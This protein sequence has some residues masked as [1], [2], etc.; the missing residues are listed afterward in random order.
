M[1]E[2]EPKMDHNSMMDQEP[3][4]EHNSMNEG[5]EADESGRVLGVPLVR[6]TRG[7]RTENV[8]AGHAA[9]VS[10]DGELLRFA[11]DAGVW[12]F[13]RSTA[14]PVQ[15]LPAVLGGVLE[16]YGLDEA[17]LAMMCASHQGGPEHLA[18]LERMLWQTGVREEQ[19]AFGPALPSGERARH[20]LLR[21]GGGPR[22]LYHVCAGKHIGMLA[23]CRLRG[24]PL[25]T[26]TRPD[27][28][29]QRELLRLV[30]DIAGMPPEAVG[31]AVD[32]CG[33][34]VFALPL[35]RLALVYARLSARPAEWA[36]DAVRASA[37]R[38]AAAMNRHP[39]LVEGPGRLAS[40]MLGDG[41]I[42]AKSG[43]QGVFV[44]ALRRER[45]A[46]ALKL[47][48]GGETAWPEA[49]C[50]ALGQLGCGGE[51]VRRIREQFPPSI[52]ND[53]GQTVG[54]TEPVFRLESP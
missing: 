39:A 52:R 54:R 3:M 27:H 35:R 21:S 4:M 14:K 1:K 6:T 26:Y 5:N 28:P 15:A 18:V 42:V 33:L 16:A 53:A 22:K 32:G 38:I 30:A 46:V 34:P 48:D 7:G 45:L 2:R 23:L 31:L 36:D 20:E 19:L 11:G 50:A 43:A 8:H 51:L 24:W 29:L 12:T 49:V 44:F 17:A 25:E 41:N 37:E 10:A 9:V 13:M 47:A 40:V